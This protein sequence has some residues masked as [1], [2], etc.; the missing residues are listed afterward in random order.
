MGRGRKL[1]VTAAVATGAI[2]SVAFAGATFVGSDGVDDPFFPKMGNTGYNVQ[3]Y[4]VDLTYK[5]SGT[6]SEKTAFLANA[7][8]DDGNPSGGSP[9]AGFDIDFQGPKITKLE[10]NEEPADF[11]REG[12]EV[13]VSGFTPIPDGQS[14]PVT[15]KWKGKPKQRTYPDGSADGWTKTK[16]GVVALGEPGPTPTWI[17]VNDHPTDKATWNI[18]IT[19]P[20]DLIGIS[21]GELVDR[22][23]TKRTTTTEWEQNEPMA[24]YLAMAAIGKFRVDQATIDGHPYLGAVDRSLD[25]A[26]VKNLREHTETAYDF[27]ASVAGPY[28]FTAIGG[29]EDPSRLGF[30]ME[31]QARPY[32][33]GSAN[34]QLII[35]ELGHQWYGDSL[36]VKAWPEIWLNEGF[37][38]YMEWLYEEQN[39]GETVADRLQRIHDNTPASD[40]VWDPPPADPGTPRN[41]FAGS[42]YDRG[43][44]ALEV[45]RL[46]IGEDNFFEVL[47]DWA[48]ENAGGNVST[49]DL[50]DLIDAVTGSPRPDSFDDWLYEVGKPD[51]PIVP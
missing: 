32:Y 7:D 36:A 46:E 49:Q 16:D 41:L 39:G 4:V 27:L 34:Q 11:T 2:A 18:S 6:A 43:A 51:L 45:L 33:P 14:F 23:R 44:M 12:Q 35:H 17:P 8:T 48:Q 19:T 9:L 21:N 40:P 38:T 10:V 24:S 20:R 3:T 15:V 50:Y 29:V 31:T 26:Q 30:A 42:V 1:A 5:K 47:H 37:A 28:P 13:I 22:N 25:R